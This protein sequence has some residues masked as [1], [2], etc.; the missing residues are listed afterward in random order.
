MDKRIL[1]GLAAV[2]LLDISASTAEAQTW[3]GAYLGVHAGY[4]W[5]DAHLSTGVY[6]L[7][8]PID[9]DPVVGPRSK[10]YWLDSR[11]FGVHAG[12]NFAL[13]PNWLLGFEID[14]TWGADK[15][16]HF[17]TVTVD[18]VGYEL[19]SHARL[20]WQATARGRLGLTAGPW[21][22]YTTAGLAVTQFQWD[23]SFS[24]P[25]FTFFV[26]ESDVRVG[27]VVGAG[28]EVF[29]SQNALVRIEY[30]YEDFGTFSV[31]LAAALPAGTTGEM[32][33]TAHKLRAGI[34]M[35]F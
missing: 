29:T 30:L 1:A 11:I 32:D 9:T 22:F 27:F 14:A 7:N 13:P 12:Y 35:K 2:T 23:E 6:T 33:L 21:L 3:S 8:N 18:G 10:T 31:P 17:Q 26:Q 34:S 20:R 25:G 28:V 4:R 19:L 15:D 5:G 16:S 24:G